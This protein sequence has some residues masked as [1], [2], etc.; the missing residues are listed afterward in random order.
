MATINFEKSY[1]NCMGTMEFSCKFGKMRKEQEF[2]VYP[3]TTDTN[4]ILL[5]SSNRWAE[6]DKDGH[7]WMSASHSFSN[8]MSLIVDKVKGKAEQ[9]QLTPEQW[10]KVKELIR[11]T[12][13]H[14]VGNNILCMTTDNSG[15]ANI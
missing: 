10:N 9:D 6:I 15:A 14:A 13:G 3:I 1:R 7:V 5:Q 2:T 4:K 8:S 12:A 11:A